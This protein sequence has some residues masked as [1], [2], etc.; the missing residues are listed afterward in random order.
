MRGLYVRLNGVDYPAT[1]LTV[2]HWIMFV[3]RW[4]DHGAWPQTL[5]PPA[6]R[7][8]ALDPELIFSRRR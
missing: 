2:E 6:R 8:Q 7:R 3:K 5:R 1:T 4:R